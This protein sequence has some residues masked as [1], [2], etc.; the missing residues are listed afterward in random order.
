MKWARQH[1]RFLSQ[2]FVVVY[3]CVLTVLSLGHEHHLKLSHED[4]HIKTCPKHHF[5]IKKNHDITDCAAC[6]ALH[7]SFSDLG[8]NFTFKALEI[9][10]FQDQIFAYKY[11]FSQIHFDSNYLRGPPSLV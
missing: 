3:T 4:I 7:H 10:L 2:L 6:F 8:E 5:S 1:K 9:Q 11:R